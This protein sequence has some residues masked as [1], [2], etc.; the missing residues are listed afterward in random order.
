MGMKKDKSQINLFKIIIII[1]IVLIFFP[2]GQK[3]GGRGPCASLS[4][5]GK[6]CY[7]YDRQPL[8]ISIIENVIQRDLGVHYFR[9]TKCE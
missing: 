9:Y 2:I 3:C 4:A 8:V 5:A 6:V 7:S 1:V